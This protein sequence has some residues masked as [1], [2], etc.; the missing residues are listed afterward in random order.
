MNIIEKSVIPKSPAKK[1]EDGIVVTNDFIAV[2]DGSTSKTSHRHL[3]WWSNG[4]YA[5]LLV[6]RYIRHMPADISCQQF[7][8][9]VT[10]A[11]SRHYES[12]Q[13]SL[14]AALPQ[15]PHGRTS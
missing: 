3:P 6:S 13:P 7:C 9:G 15:G 4:H 5:M 12:H 2:I 14:L 10:K 1:S 11:I 8:K